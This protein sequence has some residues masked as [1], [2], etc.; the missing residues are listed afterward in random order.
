MRLLSDR[1]DKRRCSRGCKE[2]DFSEAAAADDEG[3]SET[4]TIK[5]GQAGPYGGLP[6]F[7]SFLEIK[8]EK[9]VYFNCGTACF[10]L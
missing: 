10:L 7:V 9:I 4:G 8:M 5:Q 2:A 3:L 1:E 6:G